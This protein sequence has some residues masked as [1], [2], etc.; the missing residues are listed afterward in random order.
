MKKTEIKMFFT[1]DEITAIEQLAA[2]ENRSRKNYC[3][4]EIRN[5]IALSG[6][7]CGGKKEKEK[8]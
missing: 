4:N 5:L 7:K 1:A 6:Q 8:K 3:E 2:K